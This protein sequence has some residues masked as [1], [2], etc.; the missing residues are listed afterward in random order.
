MEVLEHI[1][2]ELDIN[3]IM[4]ELRIDERSED[5]KHLQDFVEEITPIVKPKAIYDVSYVEDRGCDSVTIG[6]VRFTSRV[7][8]VK[9]EK[10]ERVFPYIATCGL[11]LD[12]I[13]LAP[14]DFVRR[15]WLDTVK[16]VALNCGITHLND[17]LKLKYA[18]GRSSAM[19]PGAADQDIWPIE[20][21]RELFSIF[22]GVEQLIGVRLTESCLMVPNKSVSGILFPTEIDFKSCQLCRRE[23][24]P[25]RQAP[26]DK[27][28]RESFS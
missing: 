22:P 26:F 25:S 13:N 18:L 2:F 4:S 9:L 24:C 3:T 5:A 1:P 20:Q 14:D 16:T 6:G 8:R 12:Q 11:E 19:S 7:L 17:C 23:N 28:M 21:Q 27:N 10:A 15:F